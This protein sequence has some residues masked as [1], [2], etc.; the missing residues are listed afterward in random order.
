MR[1]SER[2]EGQAKAVRS[3]AARAASPAER[4]VYLDIAEGWTKLAAEAARNERRRPPEEPRSFKPSV[5]RA[6]DSN[7]GN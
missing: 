7:S 5:R 6:A 1:D 2:Y 3:M 4:Q